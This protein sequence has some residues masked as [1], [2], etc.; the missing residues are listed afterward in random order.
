[1]FTK[2]ERW[3]T[4]GNQYVAAA[5]MYLGLAIL[6]VGSTLLDSPLVLATSDEDCS[7]TINELQENGQWALVTYDGCP[8][9]EF[10]CGGTCVPLG[11][12]CCEDGTY[13]NA[14]YCV[15]CEECAN[16]PGEPCTL[17]PQTTIA[18]EED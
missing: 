17:P 5:V 3:L 2:I 15:C 12:I 9:E 8:G 14:N 4:L 1:M 16:E 13:G 7:Y 18:C 10:C 11:S 6:L